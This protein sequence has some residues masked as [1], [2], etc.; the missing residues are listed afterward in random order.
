MEEYRN[1][2]ES[3]IDFLKTACGQDYDAVYY[4]IGRYDFN[5]SD[6]VSCEVVAD[7]ILEKA[8]KGKKNP[9]S[10]KVTANLTGVLYSNEEDTPSSLKSGILQRLQAEQS[11]KANGMIY[12]PE[13]PKFIH[14]VSA[15]ASMSTHD[16][17]EKVKHDIEESKTFHGQFVS[18][19]KK[20]VENPVKNIGIGQLILG[21]IV[22]LYVIIRILS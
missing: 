7:L 17:F 4:Y 22:V 13:S 20:Q 15:A 6:P 12:I 5:Q 11:A 2:R 18:N 9:Y 10:N 8:T 21:G 19:L 1:I 3:I 14:L 16:E